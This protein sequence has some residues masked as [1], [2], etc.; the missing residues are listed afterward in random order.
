MN[1]NNS[2]NAS[3]QLSQIETALY[4]L[5]EYC[6]TNDWS[7]YDPYDA[8]NSELFKRLSFLGSRIPRLALTQL[9]KRCP[10]NFRKLLIIPKTQNPKALALFLKT[11]LILR[12]IGVLEDEKLISSMV[13]KIIE[14][15]SP[16]DSMSTVNCEPLTVNRYYCWGYSFPWQ[17]LVVLAPRGE[18][19]LVCTV[20]VANA[21]LDLYESK[22]FASSE[23]YL[24]PS[25]SNRDLLT[26]A[27]GAADY[28]LNELYWED[29][30][31]D[32]GFSYPVPSFKTCVHNA[33]FLASALF[34]RIYQH[35]KE[36][37]Y[38]EPALK[39][40]RYS[41]GKQLL[42][43]SWYYGEHEKQ[44]WVDNFHTGYN[45]SALR[46]I[47]DSLNSVEFEPYIQ[48]GFDFYINNFFTSDNIP[49]YF[50]NK[51]YPI[52]V[53]AVAYSI[54]TLTEFRDYNQRAMDLATKI[55]V[56]AIESMQD[57]E[58]Y[59]YYQKKKYYTNK[60]PYMRWSQAWMLY[61]LAVS[62]ES[63]RSLR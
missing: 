10:I 15:R 31:N 42:D 41:A 20:F 29:E 51:L 21:L 26:L 19:N 56:W 37:K 47:C 9:L 36:K 35:K 57:K 63:H 24:K 43:G 30:N 53:H 12:K 48:K 28:I 6:R 25:T 22:L 11:F 34:C 14:L 55:C 62:L 58:G 39:A 1:K 44:Q 61:A 27:S 50:H 33:N 13:Q 8:L 46:T 16:A 38:L 52:D 3:K 23:A 45:L 18:A 7:G 17:G 59:F 60:I 40:A 5:F 54:I 49:K 32:A 2:S 4:R